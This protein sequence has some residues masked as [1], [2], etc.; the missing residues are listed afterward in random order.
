MLGTVFGVGEIVMSKIKIPPLGAYSSV[1]GNKPV[2][3]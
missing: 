2:W 1:R 3:G